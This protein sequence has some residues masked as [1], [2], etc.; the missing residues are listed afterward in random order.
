M[1]QT[2]PDKQDKN[3]NRIKLTVFTAFIR[4]VITRIL[5]F[6]DFGEGNLV[7]PCQTRLPFIYHIILGLSI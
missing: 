3:K 2:A 1:S 7:W 4:R 6:I 5:D